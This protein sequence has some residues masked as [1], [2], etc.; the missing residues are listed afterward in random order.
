MPFGRRLRFLAKHVDLDNPSKVNSFIASQNWS[1]NYKGNVVLAYM[2]YARFYKLVWQMPF[3]QRE[4]REFRVPTSEDVSKIISHARLK[5][6]L[7]YSIIADVGLRP[8]E[9]ASLRVK[10]VDSETGEVYPITAK[11]GAARRLKLK[12]ST[13]GLFKEYVAERS[14]GLNALVFGGQESVEPHEIAMLLGNDW[15][16]LKNAVALKLQQPSLRMIRLYDLR[17]AFGTLTYHRTKDVVFTQR[18]MGHR[19]LNST[20]RY[21]HDVDFDKEQFIVKVAISTA[22]ATQLLEQGFDYVTTTPDGLMLFRK[23]K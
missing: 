15:V 21:I 11:G 10:D 20:L 3:Y 9:A 6:A 16:R 8:I 4:D 1:S 13:L 17:H 14:L 23:P 2:H 12:A 22:E 5:G 18:Q 7:F 19:S